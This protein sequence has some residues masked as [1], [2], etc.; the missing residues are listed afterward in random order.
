VQKVT[1]F[2][3]YNASA[4]SGKT[5]TLVKEYLKLLLSANKPDL[6]KNILSLTFTNKA[7]AEMK[8]RILEKLKLF[9]EESIFE[10]SDATFTAICEELKMDPKDLHEKSKRTLNTIL[11][12]YSSFDISTIDRFTHKVIRTF[13]FD[14]KIPLNFEVELDTD[15]LLSEAVDNLISKA[16]SEKKITQMLIDFALEKTDDEKSWDIAFDFNKIAK[17][18]VNENDLPFIA[19]LKEKTLED[20]DRLKH[21]IRSRK[22]GSEKLIIEMAQEA[23][24]LL[25]ESGLDESDFSGGYLP[26][27]YSNLTIKKFDV[28]LEAKWQEDLGSRTLYPKRVSA[29]IAATIEEIQP[30]LNSAFQKTKDLLYLHRF[31]NNFYK[32]LT[33]LSVINSINK[34]LQAIKEEKNLLLIS[35]FNK[36][37][38]EEIKNQPTPFIYERL[39]EKFKHYFIDEFQDTSIM[40][41]E[42]LIPLIDNRLS[43]ENGSAMIVGDAKQAIYRW[44]GGKPEL[45][46]D[47]INE[48]NPFQ[49][50]KSIHDLPT[51]YRSHKYI[52]EFNNSF[53]AHLT[54]FVFANNE[55]KQLYKNASQNVHFL[56]E[57]FVKIDFLDLDEEDTRDEIFTKA[58]SQSIEQALD[59]GFELN[60]ICVLV[61]RKKEGLAI[62][63]HLTELGIDIISSETLLINNSPEIQFLTNV[64]RF[65]LQPKNDELK[66]N[67][68][69]YISDQ[70]NIDDKHSFLMNGLSLTFSELSKMLESHEISFDFDDILQL[71]LYD[72]IESIVREFKL[73]S[74]SDAYIQFYLDTVLDYSQKES[75]SIMDFLEYWEKKK[76]D[77]SI[78]VPEG[79]NA[80]QIMTI[81]KSKGLEFPVVVFPYADLNIY[82]ERE[83]RVWFPIDKDQYNGFSN[84]LLNYNNTLA[85]FGDEGEAIY[86][87]RQSELELDNINLLYVVLT[88]AIE[89]LHILSSKVKKTKTNETSK[90][91]SAFFASYLQ[92]IGKWSDAKDTYTFGNP[93]KQK[94]HSRPIKNSL[95]PNKF[96]SIKNKVSIIT[97]AG[98]L[99]DTAQGAAIEKGN[100]VHHLMARILHENDIDFVLN[101]ALNEGQIDYNQ[102]KVLKPLL[103]SIINH[104]KLN[105]YYSDEVEVFNERD[106]IAANGMVVRPDRLVLDKDNKAIIIDYKTGVYDLKHEQQLITYSDI[107]ESMGIEVKKRILIYI[108]RGIEIKEL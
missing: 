60:D 19:T 106:V 101:D 52:V 58:V 11:H 25:E 47:L 104:P 75:S 74:K 83:P 65:S 21:L 79:R 78:T 24:T 62:S 44:R 15:N 12:N 37:I 61:R 14:L 7:V 36:I 16:G 40:Q 76:D 5:F 54:T 31:Y 66:A 33:P 34:E 2:N 84:T 57:G 68:L 99:W 39:G 88:R 71:A 26:K 13:A 53:F 92:S 10:L 3:V 56:E 107:I 93:K 80:V 29:E 1:S 73:V 103:L 77:L 97:K 30:R 94:E 69:Y 38:H 6:F 17:L 59:N 90:D 67:I 105:Q 22:E 35:E 87:R 55:H 23:L 70:L 46:I 85:E 32:N 82:K 9:S 63:S 41:W 72:A 64:L 27:F 4:G 91:F 45:F 98:F 100:L 42:N 28:N 48:A 50:E 89:Q 49:V 102:A 43:S 108:D 20:F 96:I 86:N 8:N 18:L 51:N 81:H 95:N